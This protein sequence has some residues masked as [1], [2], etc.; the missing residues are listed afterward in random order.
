MY[1]QVYFH[2]IRKIYD[3]HLRDF[4]TAWLPTRNGDGLFPT[5]TDAHLALT[6]NEVMAA[7]LDAARSTQSA[8]H[9]AARRIVEH[10]H[11]HR[12]YERN[13]DDMR[14]NPEAADAVFAATCLKVGPD[15]VRRSR[16][17]PKR[18]GIDFPVL[19]SDGRVASSVVRSDVLRTIPPAAFDFVYVEASR[20]EEAIRW[21]AAERSKII[22]PRTRE[23][24]DGSTAA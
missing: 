8:A 10:D 11:F 1:T 22:E 24:T 9:D 21:L 19:T 20:L 17:E 3:V 4:L 12:V 15:N 16:G 13:A 2:H 5:D 7:I 14:T 6:D 18:N 23:E